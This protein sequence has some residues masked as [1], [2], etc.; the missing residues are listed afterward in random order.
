MPINPFT[1]NNLT[2]HFSIH[3]ALLDYYAVLLEPIRRSLWNVLEIGTASGGGMQMYRDY[4]ES[5]T[6]VGIDNNPLPEGTDMARMIHYQRDAYTPACLQ[7]ME[8]CHR[9]FCLIVDDGMHTIQTQEWMMPR[10]CHQ[11]SED[12]ILIIEDVQKPE[13][14]A[15]LMAL[16]PR[17]FSAQAVD[18]RAINGQEDDLLFV[19]R[20]G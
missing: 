3:R 11:L 14:L 7:F 13:Y 8:E 20:R 17:Y 5:A 12:G 19:V 16:V 10:Y 15:H 18:L 6:I 9:P 1:P 4:F 2:D